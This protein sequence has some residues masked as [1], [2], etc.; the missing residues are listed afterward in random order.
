MRVGVDALSITN[1]SGSKVLLG[2]LANLARE[3]RGRHTFHVFHHSGN[4]NLRRDFGDNVEWI[5]CAG[6]GKRWP[7]RLAW[8]ALAFAPALRRVGAQVLLSSSGSLLPRVGVPQVV[9]A[10]NPWCFWPQFHRTAA[11]R[12]KAALQR[13]GYR[14]AQ[15]GAAAVFCLSDYLA[16]EYRRNAD[17]PA[18]AGGTLYCGVDDGEFAQPAPVRGFADRGMEVLCVSVMARHKRIEDIVDAMQQL[19]RDGVPARLALVGP[20]PDAGY[21]E[22][23]ETRLELSGLALYAEITGA[24]SDAALVQRYEHARV[25]CLLSGCESFGIPAVEAQLFGTPCVVADVCAPPEIA[26]PGG[27]VVPAGD[28]LAAAKALAP[29]LVDASAWQ[30]ASRR[31]L[32]NVERF[33]WSRVSTP[34]IEFLDAF[35]AAQ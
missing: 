18:R 22:E 30:E 29:L 11:D 31:A 1:F 21:R 35:E 15:R 9:L 28:P 25:F 32:A 24:V 12:L 34:L 23:I 3:G 27:E 8:Q 7:R 5:E 10:M 33:R 4:R 19:H 26:G 2:H 14:R 13:R 17:A 6:A 16:S 20:W